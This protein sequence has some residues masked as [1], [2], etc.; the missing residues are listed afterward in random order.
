M[1]FNS[2]LELCRGI[3]LPESIA[4]VGTVGKWVKVG[5]IKRKS[6]KYNGWKIYN[7]N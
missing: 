7:I 3:D 4:R 2:Y 5:Y 6:S 1:E